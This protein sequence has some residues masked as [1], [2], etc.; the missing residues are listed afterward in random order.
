MRYVYVLLISLFLSLN[1]F[2]GSNDVD[3]GNDY[4]SKIIKETLKESSGAL[5]EFRSFAQK[6]MQSYFNHLSNQ[7]GFGM[8]YHNSSPAQPLKFGI[9]PTLEVGLDFAI[10]QVDNDDKVWKYV[11]DKKDS[12]SF[13]PIPRIHVNMSLPLDLEISLAGAWIPTT[14]IYLIGGGL[15]WSFIGTHD[16]FLNVALSGNFSVL[17]GVDKLRLSSWGLNLSSSLDFK[18]LVPYIGLGFVHI[19]SSLEVPKVPKGFVDNLDIPKVKG[20]TEREI[21]DELKKH[22]KEG[23]PFVRIDSFSSVEPNFFIGTRFDLWLINFNAE[24]A[25]SYDFNEKRYINTIYS[26]RANISF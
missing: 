4:Y 21:K 7:F 9:M 2:A 6:E 19:R 25:F 20:L 13:F 23:T 8:S 3:M 15:K 14:N 5:G 17:L 24:I 16:S 22:F 12:P 1:V 18:V 11:I 26:L 10:L